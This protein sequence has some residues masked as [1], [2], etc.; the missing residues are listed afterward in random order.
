M[1]KDSIDNLQDLGIKDRGSYVTV[2][3]MALRSTIEIYHAFLDYNVPGSWDSDHQRDL[4][5]SSTYVFRLCI[6]ICMYF[7]LC[8][9]VFILHFMSFMLH[10]LAF[11]SIPYIRI[12]MNTSICIL[13][14]RLYCITYVNVNQ[15]GTSQCFLGFFSPPFTTS[16]CSMFKPIFCTGVWLPPLN[17][18]TL[19]LT[20]NGEAQKLYIRSYAILPCTWFRVLCVFYV[21]VWRC[22]YYLEP[23]MWSNPFLTLVCFNVQILTNSMYQANVLHGYA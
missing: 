1:P 15:S 19:V 5:T 11:N 2:S 6:S 20:V 17:P 23:D 4:S 12:Y 18:V 8:D 10:I 21:P 16:F 3:L 22:V 13:L 14:L 7:I 9:F